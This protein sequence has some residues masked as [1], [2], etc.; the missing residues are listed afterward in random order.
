MKLRALAAAA[1]MALALASCSTINKIAGITVDQRTVSVA[2]QAFDAAKVTGTNYLRLPT[3]TAD[4]DSLKD[5]CKK[6]STARTIITDIRA[7]TAARDSLWTASKG[8]TD[9]IG[10][11]A[12]YDAVVAATAAINSDLKK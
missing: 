10:V 7:G 12:A 1:L 6:A 2:V 11:R 3:C 5:A 8:S 4:Q 9:G